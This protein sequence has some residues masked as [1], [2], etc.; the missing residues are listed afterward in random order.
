M[1]STLTPDLAYFNAVARRYNYV[2]AGGLDVEYAV[3]GNGV[4]GANATL[5]FVNGSYRGNIDAGQGGVRIAID[6]MLLVANGWAGLVSASAGA[7][8]LYAR[9]DFSG[10]PAADGVLL[11]QVNTAPTMQSLF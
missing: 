2:G 6:P 9:L 4:S 10:T 1:A 8:A 5:P 11:S 7:I 3:L